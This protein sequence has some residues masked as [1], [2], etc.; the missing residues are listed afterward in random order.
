[1]MSKDA[2]L[3]RGR[4]G[5]NGATWPS[6][7]APCPG[8]LRPGWSSAVAPVP[9]APLTAL[10]PPYPRHLSHPRPRLDF[11]SSPCSFADLRKPQTQQISQEK[12][13]E[14]LLKIPTAGGGG[15]A[16]DTAG[17]RLPGGPG[18]SWGR[19]QGQRQPRPPQPPR[20]GRRQGGGH[21]PVWL[22][23]APWSLPGLLAFTKHLCVPCAWT[24]VPGTHGP[25]SRAGRRRPTIT[26]LQRPPDCGLCCTTW[27][28]VSAGGGIQTWCPETKPCS[29]LSQL[30][31]LLKHCCPDAGL[32]PV[33]PATL[34]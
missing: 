11:L 1:M 16:A 20:S 26:G 7:P 12:C 34:L 30:C 5:F 9:S 28:R 24:Q 33:I 31:F 13:R 23:P 14:A 21:Q 22:S 3:Q 15:V 27:P 6:Y 2:V 18:G 8:F 29:S 10:Q 25:G 4:A 17:T 32:M 19:L